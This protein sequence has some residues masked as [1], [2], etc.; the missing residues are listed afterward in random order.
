M[1]Q[2]S[3]AQ[4]FSQDCLRPHNT[5]R[6]EVGVPPMAWNTTLVNYAIEYARSRIGDCSLVHSYGPYGENLAWSGGDLSCSDAVR[7]WVAEK[8]YYNNNSNSCAPGRVCGHYTQV[9]WRNSVHVGCARVRCY[10][11]RGTFVICSYSPRGNY[12]GQ[13]PY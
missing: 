12:R 9:V 10:N 3:R 5:A 11:N 4:T 8:A 7:L 6:A 2:S 13:R 1:F